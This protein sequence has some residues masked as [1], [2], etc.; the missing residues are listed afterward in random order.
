MA[1]RSAI[2]PGQGSQS[3]GMGLDVAEAHPAARKVFEQANVILGIDLSG[4]CF[5]GPAEALEATDIQQPAIFT[6]SVAIWHAIRAI[7]PESCR[8]DTMA[9]LSLGEYTALHLAGAISFENALKVVRRRGQLMQEAAVAQP[10]GMVSLIGADAATAT[11]LCGQA[12]SAG[13]IQPANFNCPGQI[14]VSGAKAACE[15]MVEVAEA[16]GVRAVALKVAGAFHSPLMQ[17]AADGLAAVLASVEIRTP[18]V[19]VYAN[20]NAQPHSDPDAIRRQLVQQ[21]V[22]PVQWQA[23]VEAMVSDG[24]DQF[25]EIGPGRVLCG[26]MRKINR[27]AKAENISTAS[28]LPSTAA[29]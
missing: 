5:K 22:N 12:A 28:S 27:Q 24:S 9:G 19:P 21:L 29:S 10:S 23:C 2:F 26:L 3:V 4:L 17:S 25:V 7:A 16:A 18:S 8:F 1:K 11:R 6:V 15:K 14:V 13:I 20:V